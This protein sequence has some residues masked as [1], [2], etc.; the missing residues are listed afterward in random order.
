MEKIKD[1]LEIR[2]LRIELQ[3]ALNDLD[4]FEKRNTKAINYIKKY[5]TKFEGEPI[6]IGLSIKETN[7]L[8]QLL[9]G[10]YDE[11]TI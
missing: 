7:E 3:K 8:L 5:T 11:R 4:I 9:K 10:E 6:K 2:R 1:K